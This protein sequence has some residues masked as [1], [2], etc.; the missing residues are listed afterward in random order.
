MMET[1][2][3]ENID[4]PPITLTRRDAFL[5]GLRDTVPLLIGTAPFGLIY[6]A[7]AISAEL[8]AGAALAMSLFVFAGSSQ[9]IAAGLWA[10]QAAIPVIVLTTLVVNL[11][12]M[13]YSATLAPRYKHLPQ[14]WLLPLG[15]WLTD[16][17]FAIVAARLSKD[18]A[19][20]HLH[21]YQLGSSLAMYSNWFAWTVGGVLAGQVI[22]SEQAEALGFGF[23]MS[24]TFIGIVVPMLKTRP[25]VLAAVAAGLT[26]LVA[27]PLPHRL[28]LI[29][30]ALVGVAVGVIAEN[31]NTRGRGA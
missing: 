10:E 30:A 16:E 11:R 14:R 12:H 20:Q 23:A 27:N 1:V 18:S 31:L 4:S 8:S 19:P 26:A 21:W 13:L 7:L 9:F 17:T 28:G 5:A 24:V 3:P 25:M 22:S 2:T 6:G 15:F 29:V